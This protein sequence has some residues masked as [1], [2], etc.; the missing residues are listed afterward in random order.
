MFIYLL[1]H[2]Y[3]VPLTNIKME[4]QRWPKKLLIWGGLEDGMLPW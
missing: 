4:R 1:D 3:E 2:V